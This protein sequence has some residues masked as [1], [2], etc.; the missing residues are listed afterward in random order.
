MKRILI[1]IVFALAGGLLAG[2]GGGGNDFCCSD[3]TNPWSGHYIGDYDYGDDYGLLDIW[4]DDDGEI[5]GE[6]TSQKY[7]DKGNLWGDIDWQGKFTLNSKYAR[8]WGH[9]EW[10][11]GTRVLLIDG[12]EGRGPKAPFKNIHEAP[13]KAA[14][15]ASK[16][17]LIGN[18]AG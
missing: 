4:I 1:T 9:G 5:T 13:K 12:N 3:N 11:D 7:E 16:G 17:D 15:V 8:A 6:W 18:G 10:V 14:H 2:C